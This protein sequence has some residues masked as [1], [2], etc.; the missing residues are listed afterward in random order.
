MKISE[1]KREHQLSLK[2]HYS[3]LYSHKYP[4]ADSDFL[5]T[6]VAHSCREVIDAMELSDYLRDLKALDDEEN[7]DLF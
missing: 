6:L 7:K 4:W 1:M 3:N 5:N 2:E